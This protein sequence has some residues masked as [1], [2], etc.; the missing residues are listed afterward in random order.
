MKK[1]V[2][3]LMLLAF[4]VTGVGCYGTGPCPHGVCNEEHSKA[5]GPPAEKSGE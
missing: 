3:F 2:I 5:S 4:T 1:L